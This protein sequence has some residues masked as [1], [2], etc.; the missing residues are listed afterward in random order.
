MAPDHSPLRIDARREL[1]HSARR[2]YR[3]QWQ[4]CDAPQWALDAVSRSEVDAVVAF[5]WGWE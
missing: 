5:V 3:R 2:S 4:D 1:M